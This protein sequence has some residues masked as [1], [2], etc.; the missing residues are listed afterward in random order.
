[1]GIDEWKTLERKEKL[2]IMK[3]EKKPKMTKEEKVAKARNMKENWKMRENNTLDENEEIE[4]DENNESM[5]NKIEEL[6]LAKIADEAELDNYLIN[7]MEEEEKKEI[8]AKIVEE[9]EILEDGGE[10]LCGL[11]AHTPCLCPLLKVEMKLRLL[12]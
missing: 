4:N 2:E 11:C 7:I 12:K 6:E 8:E 5:E 1:M 9:F 3:N 10:K